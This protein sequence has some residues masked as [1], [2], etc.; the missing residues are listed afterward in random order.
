MA[1]NKLLAASYETLTHFRVR[2]G[3][4]LYRL[5]PS[6]VLIALEIPGLARGIDLTNVDALRNWSSTRITFIISPT[7][8][9][10]SHA[11]GSQVLS[12]DGDYQNHLDTWKQ[13]D[14]ALCT[15]ADRIQSA[16]GPQHNG[17]RQHVNLFVRPVAPGCEFVDRV[18]Q[19]LSK[20]VGHEHITVFGLAEVS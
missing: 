13:L 17:S 4:F 16:R 20:C 18:G 2:A 14:A 8:P 6:H 5:Q 3:R 11:I 12:S 7:S 9:G 19:L 10:R 1:I 15:L